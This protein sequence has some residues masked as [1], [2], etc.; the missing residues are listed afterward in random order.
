MAEPWKKYQQQTDAKPWEKYGGAR[1]GPTVEAAQQQLA[2]QAAYLR[3][4]NIPDAFK[5]PPMLDPNATGDTLRENP[6]DP[7]TRIRGALGNYVDTVMPRGADEALAGLYAAGAMAPGGRSPG[8]AF[9]EELA[10]LEQQRRDYNALNTP[11]GAG[12]TGAGIVLNPLNLIGGEF[13]NGARSAVGA[14]GRGAAVGAGYGATAGALGT[15]GDIEQ[16]ALG[17]GYGGLAGAA[18]GG[19]LSI[20]GSIAAPRVRPEVQTLID[21]GVTPTPGQIM[22]GIPNQI[23][24]KISTVIP[25][26]GDMITVSR[27]RANDEFNRAVYNEVLQPINAQIAPDIPPGREAVNAV[28]Q[29]VTDHYNQILANV[30]LVPDQQLTADIQQIWQTAQRLAPDQRQMFDQIVNDQIIDGLQRNGGILNGDALKGIMSELSYDARG[31]RS[32]GSHNERRLGER[33]EEIVDALRQG[34]YRSNPMQA[35]QLRA[36]DNAF[37]RLVRLESAAGAVGNDLGVFTPQQY[38]HAVKAADSSSRK[39][40]FAR[41]QALSQE[42]SDAGRAVLA[43]KFPNSGTPGRMV[44]ASGAAGLLGYLEPTALAAMG[45]GAAAYTSPAQRILATLM[46]ARPQWLRNTAPLLNLLPGPLGTAAGLT[47][48]PMAQQPLVPGAR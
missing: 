12:A 26:L 7:M 37:A 18:V 38:Q 20:L 1:P 14:M 31:Y 34:L 16:R 44:A 46:T 17:A 32:S 8:Q 41:G 29:A 25:G 21:R 40:Q 3:S 28:H 4:Q 27:R 23:E 33:I 5:Q 43:N 48:G 36:V 45:I 42:L 22:G 35:N 24:E 30:S 11:E 47:A 2:D 19:P 13:M 6:S 9:Q 15:E 10:R 39:N